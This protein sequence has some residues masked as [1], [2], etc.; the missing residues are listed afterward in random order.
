MDDDILATEFAYDSFPATRKFVDDSGA[1]QLMSL[2]NIRLEH[3]GGRL[4]RFIGEYE[5]NLQTGQGGNY[6]AN[7]ANYAK[8]GFTIGGG[9]KTVKRSDSVQSSN[10]RTNLVGV[11]PAVVDTEGAIGITKDEITGTNVPD[12]TFRVQITAYIF[13]VT[14]QIKDPS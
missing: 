1:T 6:N 2:K 11:I 3:L 8:F 10:L 9:Q 12:G 5:Y 14:I 13:P 7:G 4:W